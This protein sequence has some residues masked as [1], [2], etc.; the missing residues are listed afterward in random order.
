MTAA[1]QFTPVKGS[2]D[3]LA[4]ILPDDFEVCSLDASL[5]TPLVA[6]PAT[7]NVLKNWV[8]TGK[9]A[10]RH[11]HVDL[12]RPVSSRI[13]LTLS[14]VPRLRLA[15][16]NIQLQLP[17]PATTK[18]TESFLAYRLD[19]LDGVDRVRN[20]AI[21]SMDAGVFAAIWAGFGQKE[22]GMFQRL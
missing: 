6:A 16:D 7:S 20:L 17:M 10:Q 15:T 18:I 4:L 21:V 12:K 8:L 5:S 9:G 13:L 14:L 11:L 3:H 1:V 2:I 22:G 19:G